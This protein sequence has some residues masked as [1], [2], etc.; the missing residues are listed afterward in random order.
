MTNAVPSARRSAPLDRSTRPCPPGKCRR[1]HDSSATEAD[2]KCSVCQVCGWSLWSINLYLRLQYGP[3]VQ[4]FYDFVVA[5]I[6]A[7]QLN[8]DPAGIGWS[9]GNEIRL[10][11]LDQI[12]DACAHDSLVHRLAHLPPVPPGARLDSV[13]DVDGHTMI[14]PPFPHLHR[15]GGSDYGGH[16][17]VGPPLV[18]LPH[19]PPD[20]PTE[21]LDYID[22]DPE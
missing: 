7:R 10:V 17:I 8:A 15:T 22:T 20:D 21:Q 4:W 5:P 1:L 3:A 11:K 6:A 16:T 19:R 12:P 9:R 18:H 13:D 14:D 2:A